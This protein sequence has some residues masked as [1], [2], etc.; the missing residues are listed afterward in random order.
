MSSP[1]SQISPVPPESYGERFIKFITTITKSREEVERGR[2]S[3]GLPELSLEAQRLSGHLSRSS[4]D[5][6]VMEKAERQAQAQAQARKP[7]K[8][9]GPEEEKAERT[10]GTVRSP[11]AE[12]SNG[13]A[14]ATLPVVEEAGE[15]GSTSGRSRESNAAEE[16][17]SPVPG[18]GRAQ[19]DVDGASLGRTESPTLGSGPV[20]G[21]G[22]DQTRKPSTDPR[23]VAKHDLQSDSAESLAFRVRE[24]FY[25]TGPV[26]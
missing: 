14:G 25:L 26:T 8:D 9:L 24:S 10:L 1:K 21:P 16:V 19:S 20:P 22:R 13:I 23:P 15:A 2:L 7:E 18:D 6:I 4:T 11:S 5:R 3:D 12:R 17:L